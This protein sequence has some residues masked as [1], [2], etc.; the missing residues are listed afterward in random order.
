MLKLQTLINLSFTKLKETHFMS[1]IHNL[2]LNNNIYLITFIIRVSRT[3]GTIHYLDWNIFRHKRCGWF[4]DMYSIGMV[5]MVVLSE[6]Q[7]L[8]GLYGKAEQIYKTNNYEKLTTEFLAPDK[9]WDPEV[10]LVY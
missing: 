10:T 3:V 2:I 1:I 5:L 7:D 6:K 4:T 9:D 8:D